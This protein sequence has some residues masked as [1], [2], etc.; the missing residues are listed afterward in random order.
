MTLLCLDFICLFFY[1]AVIISQSS[2]FYE[3][4]IEVN[5]NGLSLF[6]AQVKLRCGLRGWLGRTLCFVVLS[7]HPPVTSR[8]N[9]N[10]AWNNLFNVLKTFAEILFWLYFNRVKCNIRCF[11]ILKD[12]NL[13]KMVLKGYIKIERIASVRK[14]NTNERF[15]SWNK[16]PI[17]VV[18][19]TSSRWAI[20][21]VNCQNLSI[22][23]RFH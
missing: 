23:F 4:H 2:T 17:F 10:I 14:S 20:T 7:F 15:S 6:K 18:P 22:S 13:L 1:T 21:W 12:I 3:T 16:L 8:T 5:F 11:E 19:C 9:N